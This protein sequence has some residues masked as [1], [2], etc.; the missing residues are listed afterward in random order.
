[1][2]INNEYHCTEGDA[3]M[4]SVRNKSLFIFTIFMLATMFFLQGCVKPEVYRSFS[5]QEADKIVVQL[6]GT[7]KPPAISL[8]GFYE[9]VNKYILL[10]GRN[11]ICNQQPSFITVH[12]YVFDS[13]PGN[14]IHGTESALSNCKSSIFGDR[15]I[16]GRYN[17]EY[18]YIYNTDLKSTRIWKY[19]ID[20]KAEYPALNPAG[21]LLYRNDKLYLDEASKNTYTGSE[22]R[23]YGKYVRMFIDPHLTAADRLKDES[24]QAAR[25]A[26]EAAGYAATAAYESAKASR[27]ANAYFN[28]QMNQTIANI[29]AESSRINSALADSNRVFAEQAAARDQ[30]RAEKEKLANE[31]EADRRREAARDR[32]AQRIAENRRTQES[33]SLRQQEQERLQK[34]AQLEDQNQR[35]LEQHRAD[36]ERRNQELRDI[37]ERKRV[38]AAEEAQR[39]ADKEREAQAEKQVKANYLARMRSD[40]RLAARNCYGETHVGGSRPS[41]KEAVS[42]IDVS[43][44]AYCPGSNIGISA[45]AK[46]FTGFDAGCFGDTTKISKPSCSPSNLKVVVDDVRVCN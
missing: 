3:Q 11:Y 15:P 27:E 14:Y 19:A 10:D 28:Q 41:G 20:S 24:D 7:Y 34:K 1:M 9:A 12:N 13:G 40:I 2:K 42:C 17:Y 32:D 8:G 29:G 16:A 4:V 30:A 38:A 45:V 22:Q 35:K 31:R 18:L 46:N 5:P 37:A 6:A 39:K 43:F 44:T 26:S 36:T 33:T 25:Q 21:S 23:S